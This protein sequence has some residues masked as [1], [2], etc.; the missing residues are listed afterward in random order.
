LIIENP[1]VVVDNCKEEIGGH[2]N[3]ETYEA[4]AGCFHIIE[5]NH[6]SECL[7]VPKL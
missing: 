5:V 7:Y 1:F 6:V 4:L 2:I 3:V